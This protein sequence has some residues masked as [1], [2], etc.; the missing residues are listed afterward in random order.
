[1]K[2]L[3]P[4]ELTH[5]ILKNYNSQK[6]KITPLKIQKLVYYVKVWGLVSEE[7]PVNAVF[8]KWAHGPVNSDLYLAFKEFKKQPISIDSDLQYS[9]TDSQKKTVDFILECYIDFDAISLSSM[10]HQEKPWIVTTNNSEI[11]DQIIAEYY[12]TQS[13]AKNFPVDENK[14]FY[15][16][17]SNMF[18]AFIFDMNESPNSDLFSYPS[19]KIYKEMKAEAKLDIQNSLDE[20]FKM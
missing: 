17:Q 15:P 5:Y 1:M 18:H 16:V 12:K 13:Y 4:L 6:Y 9:L 2:P 19:Y 14:K 7:N 20:I 10:S 8:Q 3:N 11:S